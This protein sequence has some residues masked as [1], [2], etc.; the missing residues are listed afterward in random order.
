MGE[1]GEGALRILNGYALQKR[2]KMEVGNN[3]PSI[4]V[5]FWVGS[6]LGRSLTMLYAAGGHVWLL[7]SI[8]KNH[9]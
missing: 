7:H 9:I 2:Q 3:L 1:R 8:G 5:L 6:G 4:S